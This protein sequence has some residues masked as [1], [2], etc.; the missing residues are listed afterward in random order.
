MIELRPYQQRA[1]ADVRAAYRRT[2]RVLLVAPTGFGKTATASALIQWAV[3]KGRRVVFAVHRRE[4]VRDTLRRL[5]GAGVPC[6]LVMAGERASDAPVQVCSV[7]TLVARAA[8]PPADLIVW[9][10]AHHCAADTYREIA[11]QYP[12][13]WHLGLTATPERADGVGL[14]DAFDELVVGATVRE[15]Q[16]QGYLAECDVIAPDTRRDALAMEPTAAWEK[17]AE[18]RPTVVFHRTVEESL[19]FARGLGSVCAHIDGSM[20][21]SMRDAR[22]EDFARGRTQVL[23]N[24]YVLTEGW[25]APRAKVCILARGCGSPGTYLQ[26]VGRVLRRAGDERALVVDLAGVTHEHG[27]PDEDREYSLDGIARKPTSD[28]EWIS[29]CLACGFVTRGVSR[30]PACSQ[31]GALWP[32]VE[33]VRVEAAE[34]R[35]ISDE[36]RWLAQLR[37]RAP[38]HE[39]DAELDRLLA[40]ARERGYKPGWASV[41][42]K[43]QYGFWP[44]HRRQ[45]PRVPE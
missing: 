21:R 20:G 13:A 1:I 35:K 3:A 26:M 28:R 25:D 9:D 45:W 4:I 37:S 2:K 27:L 8:A 11:A 17:Y 32:A 23:S 16:E 12:S 34:M 18:G 5:E 15:L 29:Q 22:L 41:R 10:E 31:C 44:Q 19:R 6:G 39:R 40:V 24:V 14:R 38:R 43:E 42:F 36:P 30:G 33:P 7:Q